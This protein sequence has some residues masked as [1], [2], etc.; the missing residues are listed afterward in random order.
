MYYLKNFAISHLKSDFPFVL[1]LVAYPIGFLLLL[2]YVLLLPTVV[3]SLG[4]MILLL[5]FGISIYVEYHWLRRVFKV[6]RSIKIAID[7]KQIKNLNTC[8]KNLANSLKR[9]NP[10]HSEAR[11]LLVAIAQYLSRGGSPEE[12]EF[13]VKQVFRDKYGEDY[14]P[15][16]SF[17]LYLYSSGKIFIFYGGEQESIILWDY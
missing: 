7:N 17:Y 15:L 13:I 14:T 9:G 12:A 8:A 5:F 10:G 4:T 3:L 11:K 1:G 6:L 2:Q 16:F